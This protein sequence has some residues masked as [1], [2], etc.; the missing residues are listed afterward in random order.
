MFGWFKGKGNDPLSSVDSI[1]KPKPKRKRKRKEETY[2]DKLERIQ[3]EIESH[4]K[5]DKE[6]RGLP[7][8]DRLI[9]DIRM[10][11]ETWAEGENYMYGHF[12]NYC[13]TKNGVVVGIPKHPNVGGWIVIGNE[14]DKSLSVGRRDCIGEY[15]RDDIASEQRGLIKKTM[16][17]WSYKTVEDRMNGLSEEGALKTLKQIFRLNPE[18]ALRH[19][20]DNVVGDMARSSLEQS[21]ES[22]EDQNE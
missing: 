10:N 4:V 11:P 12:F 5:Y 14:S 3:E 9:L 7:L 2:S 1:P 13:I 18:V 22:E 19:L 8:A 17:L 20:N 21:E 16:H 6:I 15:T